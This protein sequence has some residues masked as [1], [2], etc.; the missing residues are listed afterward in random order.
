M[1]ESL[2]DIG[3]VGAGEMA[4]AMVAGIV[5]KLNPKSIMASSPT[6]ATKLDRYGV[7]CSKSNSGIFKNCKIVVIACKPTQV[8]DIL[9]EWKDSVKKGK[10]HT[11]S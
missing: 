6:G 4:C 5:S 8:P 3:F 7:V 10:L 1:A 11:Q 9:K 2:P